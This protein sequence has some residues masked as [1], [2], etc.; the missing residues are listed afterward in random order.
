MKI[1]ELM[2][3]L[4]LDDIEPIRKHTVWFPLQQVLRFVG[5]DVRHSGENI[6]T[7]GGRTFDAVPMIYASFPCLMVNIKILK[8]VIE[9]DAARAKIAAKQRSVCGENCC[10]VDMS[11]ST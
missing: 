10:D 1:L 7:V 2:H 8:V 3:G 11:L 9:V 5:S 6:S 4:E